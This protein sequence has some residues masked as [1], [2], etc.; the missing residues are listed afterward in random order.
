[1]LQ[2]TFAK[3]SEL[4]ICEFNSH[5]VDVPVD[6]HTN[7]RLNVFSAGARSYDLSKQISYKDNPSGTCH[8]S[9]EN[10]WLE[11]QG[12]HTGANGFTQKAPSASSQFEPLL[13]L[14][15]SPDCEKPFLC[16]Q[17]TD[18]WE[19]FSN[20]TPPWTHTR[21]RKHFFS[22]TL[23]PAFAGNKAVVWH[24]SCYSLRKTARPTGLV[25]CPPPPCLP[26]QTFTLTSSG[27]SH[28]HS[29]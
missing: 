24:H 28:G 16:S 20:P 3:H 12:L 11:P 7:C 1:M 27:A 18:R 26:T 2:C 5:N 4:N 22:L 6:L 15:D 14:L 23:I 13:C 9:W 21:T 10:V 25:W 17:Q 8:F 29:I 19:V